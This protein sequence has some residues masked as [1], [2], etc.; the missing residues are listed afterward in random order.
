MGPFGGFFA[1]MRQTVMSLLHIAYFQISQYSMS[2]IPW[3]HSEAIFLSMPGAN[4]DDILSSSYRFYG[5]DHM[6]CPM[7]K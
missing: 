6:Q 3:P 5:G 4:N 7:E 1:E 2:I